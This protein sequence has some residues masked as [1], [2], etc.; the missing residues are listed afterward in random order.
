MSKKQ[1]AMSKKQDALIQ[2]I[3]VDEETALRIEN[4]LLQETMRE[5]GMFLAEET[6]SNPAK[7]RKAKKE[8]K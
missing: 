8:A 5:L 6:K 2:I 1:D 4:A 3:G 7:T